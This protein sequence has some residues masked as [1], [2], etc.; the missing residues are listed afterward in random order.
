MPTSCPPHAPASPNQAPASREA[1][2]SGLSNGGA[3]RLLSEIR[4]FAVPAERISVV[5]DEVLDLDVGASSAAS[6]GGNAEPAGGDG[7]ANKG[8]VHV[9]YAVLALGEGG[10]E[11]RQ[12]AKRYTQFAAF[13]ALLLRAAKALPEGVTLPELPP[14]S[15]SI[16]GGAAPTDAAFLTRRAGL[17]E[18]YLNALLPLAEEAEVRRWTGFRRCAFTFGLSRRCVVTLIQKQTESDADSSSKHRRA[19]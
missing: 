15:Y 4:G 10:V 18:A 7:S 11:L 2:G 5:P 19:Q 1:S 14:K 12:V 16:F 13:H 17:L 3:L 8:G 6:A 9:E